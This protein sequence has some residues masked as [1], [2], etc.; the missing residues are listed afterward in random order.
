MRPHAQ[1]NSG[2]ARRFHD[3]LGQLALFLFSGGRAHITAADHFTRG[4]DMDLLAELLHEQA[5]AGG[6][7]ELFIARA[8]LQV[9]PSCS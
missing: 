5:K 1:G 9:R 3:A 7:H 6:C 4:T 8:V 2:A